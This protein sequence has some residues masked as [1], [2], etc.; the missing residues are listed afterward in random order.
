MPTPLPSWL[1]ATVAGAAALAAT[2]TGLLLAPP[3]GAATG[4]ATGATTPYP[5]YAPTPPMGWNDW[6]YYQC[7]IDEQTILGNAHALVTTGLAKKGYDTVTIDD[8]WM[9]QQRDASGRLVANPKLFPDGMGYVGQQLHK[10]GLKFGIYED[11]GT[12]TCGGYPGSLGHWQQDADLF[13]SW[14]VDYVKLD[15][16]NVPSK[17]GE[18]DEQSY[19]DTY[20]AMSQALRNT[21]RRIVYSISAPAYF[22]GESNWDSVIRW[23]SQL[24]NLWREGADIALGQDTGADKWASIDYNYGY[25]VGL[26]G[27]Q[28]PGR[29]NDP[30]FLLAGDSGLT[31][32]EIQSQV[33]LWSM[34]AAPLISSTDLTH[35]SP[36]AL[37]VLGNRDVIAVDQDRLGVQGRIVQH[38]AGYDVLSKPLAGGDRA[39]ALFNSSD[40]AQTV[41]TT[42]TRA[43]LHAAAG[44]RLEDLVS[45]QVTETTGVIAADVPPHATVLL[46]VHPGAGRGLAPSTA[47][48]WHDVSTA[49]SPGTYRVTLADH[50][51]TALSAPQLHLTAPHGWT[52]S[53]TTITLPRIPAGGAASATVHVHGPQAAPGTTVTA[54]HATASYRAGSAR[55][56]TVAGEQTIVEVVPF[57]SLAAAFDNVGATSESDTTP[58]NFDG[59]GDS[60]STQALA[61]AGATPGATI[62]ANGLTFS[63]PSA[64]PGTPD[65]V[66]AS[67]QAITLG[68]KGSALGFLGAEAGFV[69]G[70]VTVTYTDGTTS[71]GQLGFPNWCC[72][73]TDAY[74]AKTAFTTDHRNTPTGPANFGISYGVFTNTVPLTPGK[75]V[76]TVTLPNAPAIHVFALTVQP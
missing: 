10:L 17:A 9:A 51:A 46:R 18:S 57:P 22:Q 49:K 71:T 74:G 32:D 20:T 2:T 56:D 68:G 72:A 28:R 13:A 27:L 15:G 50:G 19:R 59:G 67:G 52:V 34:M 39:V 55:V 5:N 7:G 30:D 29:W 58:G 26:A 36:A 41:T 24:G 48:T 16:C 4:A 66:S 64:A 43:G 14:G 33:S 69:S 61:K 1:R 73:P 45:K 42:A 70:T 75:T 35:L 53:P 12:S 8:C 63:W 44:Y 37:A 23:S 60:Y 21:H 47:L 25:N 11:A 65:N 62:S 6:S 3:A 54:I 40:R 31:R 76:A 38:G